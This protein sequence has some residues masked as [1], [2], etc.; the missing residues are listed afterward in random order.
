MLLW[1]C[2]VALMFGCAYVW[3]RL[4]FRTTFI[5]ITGSVGKTTCKELLADIL[6]SRFPTARSLRNQNDYSGVPLSILRVRPW[7]RFAVIE[8]AANGLGLMYRSA[9]LVRPDIAI[10]LPLNRN[11]MKNF[12]TLDNVAREKQALIANL[13]PRGIA[14]LNGDDTRVAAMAAPLK[15]RVIW[16]GS[17]P[18]FHYWAETESSPWPNRFSFILHTG[19]ERAQV[20]TQLVGTQWK[21]SV[22]AAVAAA[23]VSG[24]PLAEA[25]ATL[26]Q[27][28]PQNARMQPV[29]LPRG[30]VVIRDELDG[31]IDTLP[32]AFQAM[33]DASASRKFLVISGVTNS[34]RGPRDRYRE[35][36]AGIARVFDTAVFIGD[37]AEHGVRGAIAGGMRPDQAH[38]FYSTEDAERFLKAEL[39]PGDLVLLKGRVVDHITRLAFALAGPIG[40]R[41]IQCHKR[42]LCD[43]CPELGAATPL[44]PVPAPMR[45]EAVTPRPDTT[46][47]D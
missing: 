38:G 5:A 39:Q 17:S 32:P 27:T 3:R 1:H 40:C 11:H 15:Q 28:Q 35:L 34:K 36:G 16:F 6:Q 9:P 46:A 43:D 21:Y 4:L 47:A 18:A 12:R 42:I 14:L 7:H 44:L 25:V 33:Q 31:S 8:V 29:L 22:M 19:T 45:P 20:I 41:K 13:S 10:V 24:V 30:A 37:T 2:R 26:A 23:H